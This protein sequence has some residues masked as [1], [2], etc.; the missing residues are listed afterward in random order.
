MING[1]DKHKIIFNSK[2]NQVYNVEKVET[3]ESI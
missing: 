1:E 3:I 2:I